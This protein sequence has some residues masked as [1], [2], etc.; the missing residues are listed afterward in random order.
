MS[1]YLKI[2]FHRNPSIL[3]KELYNSNQNINNEIVKQINDSLTELKNNIRRKRIPENENINKIIDIIKKILDFNK[4]QK[5]KGLPC[6]LA[7]RTS[8]L[9]RVA[10]VAKVSDCKVSE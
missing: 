7:P 2:I 4:Q 8:D 5:V 10:R 3:A 9:A 1:K 6:M